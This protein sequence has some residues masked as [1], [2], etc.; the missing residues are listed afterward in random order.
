[1]YVGDGPVASSSPLRRHVYVGGGSAVATT[2]N[3][4]EPPMHPTVGD[5]GT[6]MTGAAYTTSA[7]AEEIVD[8]SAFD[9]TQS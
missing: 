8:P 3:V 2:E 7:A 5:G 9:T 6:A 4:A 1:M